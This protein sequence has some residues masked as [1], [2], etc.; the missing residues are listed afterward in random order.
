MS[1]LRDYQSEIRA[2]DGPARCQRGTMNHPDTN[3]GAGADAGRRK[4]AAHEALGA[5]TLAVTSATAATQFPVAWAQITERVTTI[6][7]PRIHYL[8]QRI[9]L[10]S[11]RCLAGLCAVSGRR[12]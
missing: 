7:V 12:G 11:E 9:P 1:V 6:P 3:T 8:A 5:Q 4:A 2:I 10:F